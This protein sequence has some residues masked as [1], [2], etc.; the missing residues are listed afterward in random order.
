MVLGS[1]PGAASL[2][3]TEYYAHPRNA[4]WPVIQAMFGGTI[5]TYADKCQILASNDIVVWDVLTQCIRPGSLDANI[6]KDSVVCN[7]FAEFLGVQFDIACIAFNGKAAEQ[8]F[9]KHVMPGLQAELNI[10]FTGSDN[11]SAH[12]QSKNQNKS[13]TAQRTIRLI[14]LPSTSPAMAALTL[15]DKIVAWGN[16]LLQNTKN[17]LL[18]DNRV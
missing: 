7:D 5:N 17:N 10:L 3:E 2:A 16:A 18:A 14:S 4:F 13:T 8:L 11:Q 15:D 6:R 12:W 9:R 1:M